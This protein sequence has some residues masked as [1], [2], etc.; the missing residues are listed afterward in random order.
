[1]NYSELFYNSPCQSTPNIM[2]KDRYCGYSSLYEVALGCLTIHQYFSK[3][4]KPAD[5]VLEKCFGKFA[6]S[7]QKIV[8]WGIK[9]ENALFVRDLLHAG[10]RTM[11]APDRKGK[12]PL[13]NVG[14]VLMVELLVN[15]VNTATLRALRGMRIINETTNKDTRIENIDDLNKINPSYFEWNGSY[16]QNHIDF[17]Q[18]LVKSWRTI[19][20]TAVDAVKS[21]IEES[22]QVLQE[23]R[24]VYQTQEP[25]KQPE[26]S[27]TEKQVVDDKPTVK[28]YGT[29]EPTTVNPWSEPKVSSLV[30]QVEEKSVKKKNNKSA[31]SKKSNK[32]NK[33]K[34]ANNQQQQVEN[35]EVEDNE[36]EWQVK[37]K[38]SYKNPT[39]RQ[40]ST[41]VSEKPYN[42]ERSVRTFVLRGPKKPVQQL[43][44]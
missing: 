23:S 21:A 9:Y 37:R 28:V 7:C 24:K 11:E 14:L 12:I 5:K 44:R 4:T 38:S 40:D 18:D 17:A 8:Y 35:N 29:I 16:S 43:S 32:S 33:P 34:S 13:G 3:S 31:G 30:P 19:D 27:K 25:V 2:V 26:Q 6:T 39:F 1:M 15:R 36:G 41:K 42:P 10:P 20:E 22:K